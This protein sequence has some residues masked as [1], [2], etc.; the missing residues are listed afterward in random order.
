MNNAQ[1]QHEFV[2]VLKRMVAYWMR[3]KL[4][5]GEGFND[6]GSLRSDV[7]VDRQRVE[8]M[9]HTILCIMDGVAGYCD[10]ETVVKAMDG[11]EMLHELFHVAERERNEVRRAILETKLMESKS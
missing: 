4:T 7:P 9:V 5:H 2:A 3:Q 6:D 10:R 11:P 8:G 1:A